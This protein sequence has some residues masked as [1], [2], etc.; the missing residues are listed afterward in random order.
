MK[1]LSC[2]LNYRLPHFALDL[3]MAVPPGITVLLGPNGAGKSS[4]LRLLAG[5]N[6]PAAGEIMLGE[7]YLY[8]ARQRIDL[9]PEQRRIG[10][11][12][13]DLAL[14]PHLDVGGNV[15]FGLKL[16]GLDR[17]ERQRRIDPLLEKLGIERLVRRSVADLSGGERQKVA[18]AR[19]LATEP[20]LLLLDEPT[21][22]LDPAARHEIRPWLLGILAEMDIPT[23][24]VSHDIEEAAFFRKRIAVMEQGRIV[25]K[26]SFHQLLRA[27]ASRFIARFVGVNYISGEVSMDSGTPV[28][29]STG[30]A[31]FLAPFDRVMPGSAYL[32]VYPWDIALHRQL[33]EGC[34]KNRI[35]GQVLDAIPLGDR[36]RL[37]LAA[38]DK[39]VAELSSRGY[40]ALGEPQPGER[41]WAVF[42]AREARIENY[43]GVL[44]C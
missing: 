15:G 31:T 16:R 35:H 38:K 30:G 34:P 3:E 14:F 39:L 44:P 21:A 6:R 27:P 23:L 36:V 20:Q 12:F 25:Q 10:M 18:L 40:Q 26:G 32:T 8:D 1:D 11:L 4:L 41:L 28:F 33:P 29:R 19:T 17:N 9:F 37:T 43:S 24:L 7:R 13:Q 5:L 42:K 2:R 22:A